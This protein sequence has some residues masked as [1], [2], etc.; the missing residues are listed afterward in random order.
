MIE[1]LLEAERLLVHGQLDAAERLY[2]STIAADPQNSIAV[3]G[4]ARV[5]LERGEDEL[6]YRHACAALEID[7]NNA[8]A[9]RLEARLAETLLARGEPVE[10]PAWLLPTGAAGPPEPTA[11]GSARQRPGLLRRILGR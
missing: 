10:R 11:A 1:S 4:L 7:A 6:A 5:A 9:L 3:V 2:T 8:A